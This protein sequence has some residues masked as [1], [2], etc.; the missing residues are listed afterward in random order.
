MKKDIE[1]IRKMVEKFL[2]GDTT[3]EEERWLYG[4]FSG[5]NVDK[6]LEEY[7]E[8]FRDYA[9]VDECFDADKAQVRHIHFRKSM[10][11]VAIGIA[12]AV[13]LLFGS[14]T[15]WNIHEDRMLAK[16]YEGSYMIVN[17]KRIDDLSKLKPHIEKTLK[18]AQEAEK[19][20]AEISNMDAAEAKVLDAIDDPKQKEEVR[21]ML[22]E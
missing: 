11:R 16:T 13:L 2:E 10:I 14:V 19:Y 4:Y 18:K 3:L 5:N 22:S 1:D 6:S 12:A 9:A 15:I 8:M 20:M 21:K 7:S 17:G